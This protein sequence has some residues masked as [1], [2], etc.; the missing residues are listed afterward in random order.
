MASAGIQE[1]GAIVQAG[2]GKPCPA[3]RR[4]PST[5]KARMVAVPGIAVR[6]P[7]TLTALMTPTGELF[8]QRVAHEL[9]GY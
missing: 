1:T 4:A 5:P 2:P 8:S 7:R 6:S 3:G 9:A